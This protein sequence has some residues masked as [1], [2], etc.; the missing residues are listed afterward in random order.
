MSEYI[1][2]STAE[3]DIIELAEKH[4]FECWPSPRLRGPNESG[5]MFWSRPPGLTIQGERILKFAK[6]LLEE[7][8]IY[9]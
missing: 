5:K 9:T 4:G 6:A 2:N 3:E 8:E 7:W 1:F